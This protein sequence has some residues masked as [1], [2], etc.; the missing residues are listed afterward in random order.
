MQL[1]HNIHCYLRN[2]E[3]ET[4]ES[5]HMKLHRLQQSLLNALEI[6]Y[7]GLQDTCICRSRRGGKEAIQS[8]QSIYAMGHEVSI[9]LVA[10]FQV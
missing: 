7:V 3:M 6:P 4:E 10:C 9:A 1:W 5:F 8:P 2:N